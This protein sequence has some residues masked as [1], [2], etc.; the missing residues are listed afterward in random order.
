MEQIIADN[1]TYVI[2]ELINNQEFNSSLIKGLNE[3]REAY[4]QKIW[5]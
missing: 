4:L 3:D 1:V 2:Q 5:D